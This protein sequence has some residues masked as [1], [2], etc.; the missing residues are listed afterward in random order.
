MI[1]H[2][3]KRDAIC[4]VLLSVRD[5]PTADMI[6]ERVRKK[7]PR[8]SLATVYR[9]LS[10]LCSEG[11]VVKIGAAGK[12]RYDVNTSNHTHFF[13]EKCGDVYDV[14]TPLN[15]SGTEDA[16]KETGGK[17]NS[18]SITFCGICKRC[19]ENKKSN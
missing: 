18:T 2:S 1:K 13:C 8:I 6:Y 10:L 12:E 11:T 16:Q 14:F 9:N 5:H 17:I 19:L 15:L 4:E 3:L 7:Y